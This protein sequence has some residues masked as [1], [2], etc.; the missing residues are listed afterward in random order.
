MTDETKV[1]SE[2]LAHGDPLTD[3]RGAHRFRSAE[4]ITAHVHSE[5]N[6]TASHDAAAPST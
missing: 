1:L 5:A 3:N 2:D 4:K 6:S